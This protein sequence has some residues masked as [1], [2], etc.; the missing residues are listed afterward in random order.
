MTPFVRNQGAAGAPGC[1]IRGLV[2]DVGEYVALEPIEVVE[3]A[4]VH[5]WLPSV[6]DEA[7][8]AMKDA[9]LDEQAN[10]IYIYIYIYMI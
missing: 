6:R 4:A 9:P 3:G 7:E 5:S 2:G 10:I 8:S 1:A